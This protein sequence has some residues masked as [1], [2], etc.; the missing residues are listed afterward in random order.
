MK[1]KPQQVV[2]LR[3][4]IS[5]PLS[6]LQVAGKQLQQVSR[7]AKLLG[8]MPSVSHPIELSRDVKGNNEEG[9]A[10]DEGIVPDFGEEEECPFLKPVLPWRDEVVLLQVICQLLCNYS[11]QDF[12]DS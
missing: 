1:R 3:R 2:W 7:V 5:P 11:L 9:A 6:A 12:V 4:T 10:R 8:Q